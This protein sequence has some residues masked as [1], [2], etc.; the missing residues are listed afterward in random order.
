[1]LNY[2][3]PLQHTS[4]IS[5]FKSVPKKCVKNITKDINMTISLSIIRHHSP[6]LPRTAQLKIQIETTQNLEHNNSK[7][8]KN[9]V[10]T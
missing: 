4:Q 9:C 3:L 2:K 1:M 10:I 6:P 7:D 5:V 8:P